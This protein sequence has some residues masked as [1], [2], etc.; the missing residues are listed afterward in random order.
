MVFLIGFLHI[1]IKHGSLGMSNLIHGL[2]RLR[3]FESP[4]PNIV[5]S[6]LTLVFFPKDFVF[7][8][9]PFWL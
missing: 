8:K 5:F 7:I 9:P 3:E 2:G 1:I 6:S 4:S